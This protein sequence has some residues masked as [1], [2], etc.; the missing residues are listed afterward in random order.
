MVLRK[1]PTRTPALLAANRANARKSTGPRRP[2][3]KNRVALS[4]LRHGLHTP[5]FLSALGKSSRA[6]QDL[7]AAGKGL[8]SPPLVADGCCWL[9]RGAARLHVVVT[10][11]ASMGHPLLGCSSLEEVPEGVAPR[12]VFKLKPECVRKHKGNE[13]EGETQMT[14]SHSMCFVSE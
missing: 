8:R 12:V 4:A 11:T 10:V 6:L 1:S 2:E 7:G 13:R 14:S 9:G 5:D 3:G